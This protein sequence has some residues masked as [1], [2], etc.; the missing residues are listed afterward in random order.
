MCAASPVLD[1]V[2]VCAPDRLP[3]EKS[4]GDRGVVARD[5]E[6]RGEIRRPL[7]AIELRDDRRLVPGPAIAG[8]APLDAQACDRRV[9][10]AANDE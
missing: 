8:M 4:T 10:L 2:G 1:S 9:A 3:V 5:L 7:V 6:D